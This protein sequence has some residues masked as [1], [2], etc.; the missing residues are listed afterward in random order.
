M[1]IHDDN[2]TVLGRNED[3]VTSDR[4]SANEEESKERKEERANTGSVLLESYCG[5]ADFLEDRKLKFAVLKLAYELFESVTRVLP[6][7]KS[8]VVIVAGLIGMV[9]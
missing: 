5:G 6:F 7:I 9:C 8:L 2:V 4:R 3:K 1:A